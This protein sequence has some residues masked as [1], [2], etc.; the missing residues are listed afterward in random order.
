MPGKTAKDAFMGTELREWYGEHVAMD[1][2]R[3]AEE[4]QKKITEATNLLRQQA[5]NEKRLA[6]LR[7]ELGLK[8]NAVP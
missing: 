8:P 5:E 7:K 3:E 4:R 6:Q 2:R 1:A